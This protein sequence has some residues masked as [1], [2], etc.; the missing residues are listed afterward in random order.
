MKIEKETGK[1]KQTTITRNSYG[2][3]RVHKDGTRNIFLL[4][5]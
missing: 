1:F 5:R 4:M 3:S 2:C